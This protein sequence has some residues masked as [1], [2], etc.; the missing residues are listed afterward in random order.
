MLIELRTMA[1]IPAL[2]HVLYEEARN[3]IDRGS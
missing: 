2:M 1:I 3:G